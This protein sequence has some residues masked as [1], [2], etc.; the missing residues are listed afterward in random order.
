MQACRIP[1]LDSAAGPDSH[2]AAGTVLPP[3]FDAWETILPRVE[4]GPNRVQAWRLPCPSEPYTHIR[5]QMWPDGGI[6]RFRLWGTVTPP[7]GRGLGSSA[8]M[9]EIDL[10][11]AV[12]GARCVGVSDQHFGK[13]GNLTL[14]GHGDD[15]GDGWETKR[16]RGVHVDWAVI[17]L[18]LRGEITR[19]VV[20]TA[21]FRGNYPQKVQ[22]F[23]ASSSASASASA[24]AS[25][26]SSLTRKV[27]SEVEEKEMKEVDPLDH[28]A[29][30]QILAP[31][32]T[33]P[34]REHEYGLEL[35]DDV[36]G[37]AYTHV[38]LVI[39]PDGGVKRLRVF[40]RPCA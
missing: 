35:L 24:S 31:T 22:L 38:K 13:G 28:D 1:T 7:L 17:R 21:H 16:S 12:N 26:A 3:D 8:D 18:G 14:P 29:W 34:D 40:G 15:M 30:V 19:V 2:E 4:C 25:T 32:P 33:G 37:K 39:I 11:A 27:D 5:L 6:A 36:L 9:K 10:G 20:D 23:A